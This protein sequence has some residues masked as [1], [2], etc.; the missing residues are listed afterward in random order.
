MDRTLL[1][2][3]MLRLLAEAEREIEAIKQAIEPRRDDRDGLMA[4][5]DRRAAK[6]PSLR[7]RLI[8]VASS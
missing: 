7:Q 4:R 5:L 1:R 8:L 6:D 2:E 3:E